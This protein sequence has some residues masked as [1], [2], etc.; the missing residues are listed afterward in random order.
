MAWKLR[1]YMLPSQLL[2][3]L[4]LSHGAQTL[5]LGSADTVPDLTRVVPVDFTPSGCAESVGC[6]TL[7]SNLP[8]LPSNPQSI[9][10]SISVSTSPLSTLLS[11]PQTVQVTAMPVIPPVS[12]T[13][14]PLNSNDVTAPPS[15]SLDGQIR[16][17]RSG[18]GHLPLNNKSRFRPHLLLVALS[19]QASHISRLMPCSE[20]DKDLHIPYSSSPQE[21]SNISVT[22]G[23]MKNQIGVADSH[24]VI[25]SVL[26]HG[27]EAGPINQTFVA[28]SAKREEVKSNRSSSES[29]LNGG[30]VDSTIRQAVVRVQSPKAR[31]IKASFL[32]QKTQ[33]ESMNQTLASRK[34]KTRRSRGSNARDTQ[35]NYLNLQA[36]VTLDSA[37]DQNQKRSKKLNRNRMIERDTE[38]IKSHVKV[39]TIVVHSTL[40]PPPS[41]EARA[42]SEAP[43]HHGDSSSKRDVERASMR[44]VKMFLSEEPSRGPS[45][46]I[47][48]R[49]TRPMSSQDLKDIEE[50]PDE[51]E[52]YGAAKRVGD[53]GVHFQG[54]TEERVMDKGETKLSDSSEGKSESQHQSQSDTSFRVLHVSPF[55]PDLA[56]NDED[57]PANPSLDRPSAS[58]VGAR[59]VPTT[60]ADDLSAGDDAWIPTPRTFRLQGGNEQASNEGKSNTGRGRE[61][62]KLSR[63]ANRVKI[64]TTRGMDETQAVRSNQE[65][66][67]SDIAR[68][69]QNEAALQFYEKQTNTGSDRVQVLV[70]E[71]GDLPPLSPTDE[72][73]AGRGKKVLQGPTSKR[74]T[75]QAHDI[76]LLDTEGSVRIPCYVIIFL[77]GMIG[78]TLVIVT[79]LQNRKMRTITNVFLLNLV[80]VK[81]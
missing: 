80:S 66:E 50:P 4:L 20:H 35:L 73:R 15:V 10:H 64:E 12:T 71:H 13:P 25:Q 40:L 42:L 6:Y 7:P 26:R 38:Q 55:I 76:P 16:H 53:K 32:S 5:E 79:L 30:R 58:L 68:G 28:R 1:L 51:E 19:Q 37:Q 70:Q 67:L 44:N 62:G 54:P 2:V 34:R 59:L 43:G 39:N 61:A 48:R 74:G 18:D 72:T 31:G 33:P 29:I 21:K 3:L 46:N 75:S 49:R 56:L 60:S 57:S 17:N 77:L 47:S 52:K 81:A 27:S 78:N 23:E 69:I 65:D 45:G 22:S 63:M 41:W 24:G 9:S 11:N 8:L 14:L 36:E